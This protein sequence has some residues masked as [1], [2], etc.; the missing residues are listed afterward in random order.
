MHVIR[1]FFLLLACALAA[2]AAHAQVFRSVMP[3]GKIVFGNKPEP[4]AKESKQINLAPLNIS[5]PGPGPAPASSGSA[6]PL[7]GAIN[8]TVD[9]AAARQNLDAAQKALAAGRE[10]NEGERIGIATKGGSPRSQLTDAYHQRIKSL[11]DAVAAAQK[12]HDEAQR[13]AAR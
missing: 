11:E 1:R 6:E 5:T 7:P 9:V 3:D 2:S 10:P 8:N 13:A 12:Q 4:G